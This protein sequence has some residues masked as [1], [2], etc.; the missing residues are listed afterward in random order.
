M[1]RGSNRL[2]WPLLLALLG[3]CAEREAEPPGRIV[4]ERHCAACH[5]LDGKGGGPLAA[6][7]TVP[8]SDLTRLAQKTGGRFDED[9]VMSAIDGRR[10]VEAHGPRDMPVWG[11]AFESEL[12]GEPYPRY[13]T[14]LKIRGLADYLRSIQA[15]AG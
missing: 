7:L 8:P 10:A 13:T 12:G 6:L 3:G 1:I 5:G 9:Q 4:F 11:S 2:G 15:P 14:F